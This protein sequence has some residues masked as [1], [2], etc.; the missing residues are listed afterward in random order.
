MDKALAQS[1]AKIAEIV[2]LGSP[3][4]SFETVDYKI[5]AYRVA[6]LVR[7]DVEPIVKEVSYNG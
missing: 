3:R 5:H 6:H 7:I 1:I 2:Q 4:A